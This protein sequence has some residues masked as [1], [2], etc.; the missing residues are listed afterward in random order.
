MEEPY[1]EFPTGG[2]DHCARNRCYAAGSDAEVSRKV[3]RDG[4]AK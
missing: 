4:G 1:P 2:A 3:D